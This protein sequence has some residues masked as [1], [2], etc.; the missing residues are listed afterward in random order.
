MPTPKKQ[1]KAQPAKNAA[2]PAA[3]V[4]IIR[5]LAKRVAEIAA[6]PQQSE[7]ADR[8]RRFNSLKQDRP[9]VLIFPEGA[10]RET[11]VGEACQCQDPWLRGFEWHFRAK[12]YCHEVLKDD[13]MVTA[14]VY[15]PP[16]IHNTGFGLDQQRT[17]P[18]EATGAHHFEP[19]ILTEA[20]FANK[21]KKPQVTVDWPATEQQYQQTAELF[22]GI[23]PVIKGAPG[24]HTHFSIVDL[25]ATWRG[26]DR[27]MVDMIDR[28]E[29]LHQCFQFM[30]DASLNVLR[31]LEREGALYLNNGNN[32]VGSGGVGYT[33]ELPQKDFTGHVRPIDLWGM[34]TTQI[35]SEVSPRMHDEFA[36]KY[37]LQ[38]LKNFGLNSY[39]C[40][41]PLHKKLNEVLRIPRLRRIS[42]SPWVDVA[43]AA[44][45]LG[46]RYI[47][48]RKPNP[49]ILASET[50]DPD[51]VR[52]VTRA[53]L[54]QT[55]G[56]VVELIMKDTHTVR[57]EPQRLAEWVRIARE[58][59]DR[60]VGG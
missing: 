58:E 21:V 17:M 1:K 60:F 20:D 40:C 3:E 11:G 55:R 34:A 10:W 5:D 16:V 49:A 9:M 43:A 51:Y 56:C 39:G 32:Y 59:V 19:V 12:I 22:A 44:K 13:N 42:M 14:P 38:W 15:V 54:E 27:L 6:L 18:K 7:K 25:F 45:V 30:T 52:K 36:L 8:W 35:F 33:D 57:N 37:E 24:W 23:L 53:D 48:S 4:K 2:P 29:W 46:N 26:L 47:F 31:T 50:W 41:E 28:P